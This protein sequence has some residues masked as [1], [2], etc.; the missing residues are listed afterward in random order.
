MK[1]LAM[2]LKKQ[3]FFCLF[4]LLFIHIYQ[5]STSF[6]E[7]KEINSALGVIVIS[8]GAPIPIWNQEVLKLITSVNSPYPLEVAFLDYD[9]ERTLEKA[10]KRMED[11][12]IKEI[13]VVHLSPSSYSCHHEEIKYLLG[14]RKDLGIYTEE[15]DPPIESEVK[16]FA[17]S[18]C[19]DDHPL[20]VEALTD[21]AKELS[22]N[23]EKESLILLGHGPVEEIENIMWVRQLKHIGKNIQKTLNFKEI[24][25]M[26][27]RNDSADLI[28]EQAAEDLKETVQKLSTQSRVIIL[29]YA[30]GPGMVQSEVKQI[31]KDFPSIVIGM[32]GVVSHPNAA[33]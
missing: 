23:P 6:A 2:N 11:R 26:T 33:K 13:S 30:I 16:R 31:L 25:C 7:E 29:T 14:L 20:M 24:V 28:R 32:K 17:V 12:D 4:I 5:N 15:A 18:P 1:G 8:H 27:L 19:M 21:Y 22:E 3:I 10:V 9:K